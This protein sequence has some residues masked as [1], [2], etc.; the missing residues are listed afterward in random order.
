MA[1]RVTQDS[2][3]VSC[4]FGGG[5]AICASPGLPIVFQSG[6]ELLREASS[7]FE[8]REINDLAQARPK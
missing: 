5:G 2:R 7:S 6:F 8:Y 1:G 4:I 3:L